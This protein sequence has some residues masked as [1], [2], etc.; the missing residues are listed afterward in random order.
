MALRTST[1]PIV[2]TGVTAGSYGSATSDVT[3]T[4]NQ[5]GQVTA[6][7]AAPKPAVVL[8]LNSSFN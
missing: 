2:P 7:S 5:N 4:V 3:V 1:A 8:Y 6:A